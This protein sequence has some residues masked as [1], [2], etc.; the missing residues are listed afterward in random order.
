M[1]FQE[2]KEKIDTLAKW[3]GESQNI[4]FSAELGFQQKAG[5]PTSAA[6]MAFIT[7]SMISRRKRF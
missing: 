1:E 3:V 5:S 7:K 2:V 4:V 6:S